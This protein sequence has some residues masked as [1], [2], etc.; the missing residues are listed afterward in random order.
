MCQDILRTSID[1]EMKVFLYIQ[2]FIQP[3]VPKFNFFHLLCKI[4]L[5]PNVPLAMPTECPNITFFLKQFSV[6]LLLYQFN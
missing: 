1:E 4:L 5:R 2:V 3:S 6:C